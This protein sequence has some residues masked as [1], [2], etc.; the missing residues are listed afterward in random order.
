MDAVICVQE[1]GLVFM[2]S[3]F[4]HCGFP[5][6]AFGRYSEVLVQKGYKCVLFAVCILL[7]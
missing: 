4:A 3:D 6:A 5:E 1:L 7:Q 2:K